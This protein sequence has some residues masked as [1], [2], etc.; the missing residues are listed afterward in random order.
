MTCCVIDFFIVILHCGKLQKQ[1]QEHH[2]ICNY[3]CNAIHTWSTFS[4]YIS[5]CMV[6][7]V[8]STTETRKLLRSTCMT[9]YA[10]FVSDLAC[11]FIY[12]YVMAQLNLLFSK[13]YMLYWEAIII[14][15]LMHILYCQWWY[16]FGIVIFNWR[17][18]F[19]QRQVSTIM[20]S[21]SIA[22]LACL[23][24]AFVNLLS[25]SCILQSIW[26][27]K[28]ENHPSLKFDIPIW[29]IPVLIDFLFSSVY[30]SLMINRGFLIHFYRL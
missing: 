14:I 28:F 22:F 30:F 13:L 2:V 18:V 6:N 3:L 16:L 26:C 17:N 12:S 15:R 4:C 29:V 27:F 19:A 5:T 25:I 23:S 10:I 7:H 9:W 11:T 20:Y 21:S 24:S 1:P 8:R